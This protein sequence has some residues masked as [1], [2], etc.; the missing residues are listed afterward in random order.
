VRKKKPTGL[1]AALGEASSGILSFSK[2]LGA[3]SETRLLYRAFL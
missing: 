2:L 3:Y 1:I